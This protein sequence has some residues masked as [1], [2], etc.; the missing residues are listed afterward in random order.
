MEDRELLALYLRRSE[1]AI[2][3]TK[4]K[5]GRLLF[6][7]A[8]RILNS[9]ED[10]EECENETYLR[11]WNAIPPKRPEP[12]FPY[13]GKIARNLA[14]HRYEYYGAEKRGTA[15]EELFWELEECIAAPESTESHFSAQELG[16]MI[17]DF[18]RKTDREARVL[19]V[20][21]YWYADSVKELAARFGFSES[22]VKSSLSRTRKRL[23]IYLEE[24]GYTL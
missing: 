11:A 14:L 16:R 10:A 17:S 22:K 8:N 24:E 3:G 15:A 6:S 19:F 12:F 23:R 7:I 2:S 18:L 21:R 20:R 9:R 13:L 5:Y 4:Q 1:E